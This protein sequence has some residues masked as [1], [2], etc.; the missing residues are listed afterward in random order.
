MLL[1]DISQKMSHH[2]TAWKL[3]PILKNLKV[4]KIPIMITCRYYKNLCDAPRLFSV[5]F[6]LIF[7]IKKKKKKPYLRPTGASSIHRQRDGWS[8]LTN[9]WPTD[10]KF[11][12]KKKKKHQKELVYPTKKSL[13]SSDLIWETSGVDILEKVMILMKSFWANTVLLIT[14]SKSSTTQQP[15]F[16]SKLRL[17]L[18]W[19]Q[20]IRVEKGKE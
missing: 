19:D 13:Y 11:F 14:A 18:T 6:K 5:N 1:D 7:N 3:C 16:R 15:H 20:E 10:Q 17:Q 4:T 12:L 8:G 2:R 9:F